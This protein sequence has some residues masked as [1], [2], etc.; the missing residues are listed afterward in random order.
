MFGIAEA[1][2]NPRGV[3]AGLNQLGW[4]EAT[5]HDW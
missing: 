2:T 5:E 4:T 1:R 3:Y